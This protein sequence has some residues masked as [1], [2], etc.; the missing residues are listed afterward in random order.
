L[1]LYALVIESLGW[2]TAALLDQ[3][4]ELAMRVIDD[5]RKVDDRCSDLTGL[6]KERIAEAT[7]APDELED[8]IAIL[9]M[10]PELE[11]SADLAEHVA[12]R[13]KQDL[14]GKISPRCRGLIQSMCDSGVRMW[15]LSSRAYA[16]HSRD[17]SFEI[18]ES[19]DEL[20]N[21]SAA[22]LSEAASGGVDPAVS[23]ELA[24]VARFYERI[25][26]H[27]VNL[28][29]RSAAMA[30]PRRMS[31][32]RALTKMRRDGAAPAGLGSVP[33]PGS[34]VANSDSGPATS[35]LGR[36]LHLRLLPSD[37]RFFDL[38]LAAATNAR[39][40]AEQLRKMITSF[41]GLDDHYQE[42]RSF[43]RQGDQITI[44][45][46][47]LL[48]ATFVTPYDREDIYA[49]TQ[50]IDDVVDDMF[51]VADLIT[52]LKVTD[53]LPEVQ[54]QAETL[55]EMAIELEL[56]VGNMRSGE[57]A[58][59]RLERIEALEREGDA[60][61]R[62]CIARLFSGEFEAMDVLKWKDIVQAL[63]NAL[64]RVEDASDVIESIL[65]KNA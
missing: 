35:A 28:A 55:S 12:Q 34:P 29:R 48:D 11:R 19:D 53:P 3:D 39:D 51:S 10:V 30:A 47:R 38:F 13:A 59:Q 60:V 32:L 65:V 8:L 52:L 37:D 16:E 61:Y 5:D 4:I 23:A 18:N 27:A 64:N 46:S 44:E 7:V 17:L 25:G 63:E 33:A 1:V 22:L 56:L 58:R 20:D 14:G 24:L 50:K 26:D 31:P 9:Q 42:I 21:L 43:E 54:Q 40:C 2:A 45:L 36:L 57:G 6:I 62:R 15:Q 49:L 41:V